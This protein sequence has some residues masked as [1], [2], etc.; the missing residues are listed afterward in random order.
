MGVEEEEAATEERKNYELLKT[1]KKSQQ[2]R[3]KATRRAF[4]SWFKQLIGR[5][6]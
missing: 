1:I 2:A 5:D 6:K 3:N 4:F